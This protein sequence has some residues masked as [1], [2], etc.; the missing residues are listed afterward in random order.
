MKEKLNNFTGTFQTPSS[1]KLNDFKI[2]NKDVLSTNSYY[3]NTNA[4]GESVPK[5]IY[6]SLLNQY[7]E[8]NKAMNNLQKI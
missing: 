4:E 7:N 2:L 8:N 1:L 6:Q 5:N 3:L